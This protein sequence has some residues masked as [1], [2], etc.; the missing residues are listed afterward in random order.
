MYY[1][2]LINVSYYITSNNCYNISKIRNKN[3]NKFILIYKYKY[4]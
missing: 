3:E 1:K 2:Q 4:I